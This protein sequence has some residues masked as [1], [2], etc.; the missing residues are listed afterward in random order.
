MEAY[1]YMVSF[2]LGDEVSLATVVQVDNLLS[3]ILPGKSKQNEK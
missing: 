2:C 1:V 3:T